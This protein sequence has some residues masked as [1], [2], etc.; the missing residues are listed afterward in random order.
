MSCITICTGQTQLVYHV[1]QGTHVPVRNLLRYVASAH[2]GYSESDIML[3]AGDCTEELNVYN[4]VEAGSTVRATF[5]RAGAVVRS[6]N[7][8]TIQCRTASF[9]SGRL[10]SNAGR[11]WDGQSI[12]GIVTIDAG[13]LKLFYPVGDRSPTMREIKSFL[14]D[15]IFDSIRKLKLVHPWRAV[16]YVGIWSVWTEFDRDAAAVI[17]DRNST[18]PLAI[19]S[20]H[21]SDLD[22]LI[23][24]G[25]RVISQKTLAQLSDDRLW[26]KMR[27]PSGVGIRPTP[28]KHCSGDDIHIAFCKRLAPFLCE[29]GRPFFGQLASTCRATSWVTR[30]AYLQSNWYR[31]CENALVSAELALRDVITDRDPSGNSEILALASMVERDISRPLHV[32]VGDDACSYALWRGNVYN[33]WR[34]MI[35]EADFPWP[36]GVDDESGPVYMRLQAVE[37]RC[38]TVLRRVAGILN[39]R[40]GS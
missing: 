6:L 14:D 39:F 31:R 23:G 33:Y 7:R 22:R 11:R 24:E 28:A 34:E 13:A 38:L 32:G 5:D 1:K 10:D 25:I 17:V 30:R 27:R 21:Q 2:E 8:D 37:V 20:Y 19:Q 26:G 40:E 9:A 16:L 3:H 36:D 12:S 15:H 18:V 4:T 35:A 29:G